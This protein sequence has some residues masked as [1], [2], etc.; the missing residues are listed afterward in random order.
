MA[1]TLKI[2]PSSSCCL[3]RGKAGDLWKSLL[4]ALDLPGITHLDLSGANLSR[5]ALGGLDGLYHL[6]VLVLGKVN[7]PCNDYEHEWG[8]HF[9]LN[10]LLS[11]NVHQLGRL[12]VLDMS[13]CQ[14]VDIGVQSLSMY[15]EAVVRVNLQALKIGCDSNFLTSPSMLRATT[16]LSKA[17]ASAEDCVCNTPNLVSLC[18]S[19]TA[20]D[21]E[22]LS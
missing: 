2:E 7:P 18:F 10:T 20:W 1:F 8:A 16:R 3:S 14:L 12:Q 5:E 22:G 15:L 17:L 19:G 9:C 11:N 6:K 21:G 4:M 13:A